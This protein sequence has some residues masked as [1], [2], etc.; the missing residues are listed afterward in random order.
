MGSD[1]LDSLQTRA[2]WDREFTCKHW[3]DYMT[4]R[5]VFVWSHVHTALFFCLASMSQHKRV[6]LITGGAQGIGEA[7]AMRFAADPSGIDI[8]I[9]DI[10]GKEHQLADVARRVQ[11]S[12]S[13]SIWIA[14]DVSVEEEVKSAVD[15]TV[16]EFGSLDI[17]S[18]HVTQ[19]IMAASS[20]MVR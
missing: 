16:S 9:L 3:P 18:T 11:D 4:R 8:A 14:A 13:K 12:G 5:S 2:L 20:P 15:R 1:S 6:A 10:K 7:I 17:V 19:S